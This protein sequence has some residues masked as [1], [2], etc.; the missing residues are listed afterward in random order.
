MLFV[1]AAS[2]ATRTV[3]APA[4]NVTPPAHQIWTPPGSV[5]SVLNRRRVNVTAPVEIP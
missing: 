2:F 1:F 5:A 3:C 4:G